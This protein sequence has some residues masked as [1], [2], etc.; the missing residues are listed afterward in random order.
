MRCN[1]LS[2]W[3]TRATSLAKRSSVDPGSSCGPVD[4]LKVSIKTVSDVNSILDIKL[5]SGLFE[6]HAEE[7]GE[8]SQCQDTTLLN[9]VGN[10]EGL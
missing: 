2:V 6:Q 5:F 10:W 4:V 9:S 1:V 8:E 3:A 7:D